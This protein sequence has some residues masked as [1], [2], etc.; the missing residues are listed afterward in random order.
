MELNLFDVLL[1]KE[2]IVNFPKPPLGSLKNNYTWLGLLQYNS[3]F[4]VHTQ[5]LGYTVAIVDESQVV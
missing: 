5:S 1:D 3:Y 4:S 2:R